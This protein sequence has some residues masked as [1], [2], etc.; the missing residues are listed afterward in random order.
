MSCSPSLSV[1]Q[2]MSVFV[3]AQLHNVLLSRL[4]CMKHELK[5]C[6]V[7]RSI[8]GSGTLSREGL[9]SLCS[10]LSTHNKANNTSYSWNAMYCV[11]PFCMQQKLNSIDVG[12][13]L[14]LAGLLACCVLPHCTQCFRTVCVTLLHVALH[15]LILFSFFPF[16]FPSSP[17]PSPSRSPSSASSS[18]CFLLSSIHPVLLAR[19]Q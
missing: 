18:A 15:L 4:P 14:P 6:Q 5:F 12:V 16:P 11:Q 3:C 1:Q 10:A 7:S 13:M 8:F 19:H 17:P 2:T 9:Y